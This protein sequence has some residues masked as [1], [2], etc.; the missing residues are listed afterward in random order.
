MGR[1]PVPELAGGWRGKREAELL[2]VP[3]PPDGPHRLQRLQGPGRPVPDL[4][5]GARTSATRRR[6]L[7]L[8]GVRTDNPTASF[9]VDYDIP[10]AFFDCRPGRRRHRAPR[11][12]RRHGRVPGG[13]ATRGPTR[14]GGARRSSSTSRT[15]ASSATSSPS[16]APPTRCWRSSAASTA[17]GSS[18][19]SVARIYE[20]KL[21][22]S[23]KGPKAAKDLGYIGD[24]LRGPVPDPGRPAVHEV[25]PD[26]HRRRAAAGPIPRDNFELWPAKRREVIIDFT[27]YKDGTPTTKGDVIYLTNVMKM[28]T[29]GCGTTPRGSPPTRSTRSRCWRSASATRRR[30]DNSVIPD[31]QHAAA[32]AAAEQLEGHAEQPARSSRSSAAAAAARSSG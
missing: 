15:T 12:P 1:Q 3:R 32:A 5:P 21:M 19:A 28:T 8:P 31:E 29:A 16:T 27:K 7:R 2:L 17:S 14:S 6:G 11:H 25:H 9:D 22:S 10:L 20:F 26:R 4:R 13:R 30:P 24:E 23:T 18:T